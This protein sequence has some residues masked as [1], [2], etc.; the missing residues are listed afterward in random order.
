M[1]L[2]YGAIAAARSGAGAI[3][4]SSKSLD[5]ASED[6]KNTLR[7]NGNYQYFRRGTDKGFAVDT[8]L[9]T[10]VSATINTLLPALNR[11]PSAIEA[12]CAR[13]EELNRQEEARRQKEMEAAKEAAR[14]AT[15][16]TTQSIGRMGGSMSSAD[17]L[18]KNEWISTDKG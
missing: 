1:A 12:F 2:T 15:V 9:N 17:S 18:K 14:G 6:M 10:L 11:I 13:Q 7:S 4:S 5:T 16:D 8:D 3:A